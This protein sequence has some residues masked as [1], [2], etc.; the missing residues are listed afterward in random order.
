MLLL[1]D[2]GRHF[3]EEEVEFSLLHLITMTSFAA[4]VLPPLSFHP[5]LLSVPSLLVL[6]VLLVLTARNLTRTPFPYSTTG[7]SRNNILDELPGGPTLSR[8]PVP[9]PMYRMKRL[10]STS[11]W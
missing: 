10:I 7:F 8:I 9:V 5:S 6:I 2:Y 3:S 11:K 1:S 4:T